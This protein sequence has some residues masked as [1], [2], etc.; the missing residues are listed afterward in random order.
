MFNLLD[1]YDFVQLCYGHH[2]MVTTYYTLL[3][4]TSIYAKSNQD[5]RITKKKDKGKK[6]VVKKACKEMR[7]VSR[8][9]KLKA[10]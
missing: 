5:Q 6:N 3:T 4:S 8:K 7:K 2:L 10:Y 1:V 9:E